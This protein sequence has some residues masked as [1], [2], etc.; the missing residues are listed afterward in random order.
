MR[1]KILTLGL[2]GNLPKENEW[3]HIWSME[4]MTCVACTHLSAAV[5]CK[6]YVNR[7]GKAPSV[8]FPNS[9]SLLEYR[10][11]IVSAGRLNTSIHVAG[12]SAEA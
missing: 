1:S 4:L 8:T 12:S 6:T 9:Q 7:S 11:R 5:S 3:S 2:S 10:R